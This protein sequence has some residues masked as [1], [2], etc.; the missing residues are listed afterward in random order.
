MPLVGSAAASK[1]QDL[2]LEME[3]LIPTFT[4]TPE[5]AMFVAAR[6]QIA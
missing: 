1:N 4:G 6:Y 5:L 3:A 2:T